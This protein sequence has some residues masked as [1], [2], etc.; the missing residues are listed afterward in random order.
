[1][2]SFSMSLSHHLNAHEAKLLADDAFASTLEYIYNEIYNAC[3]KGR[4]VV[5]LCAGMSP[6]IVHALQVQGYDVHFD[7]DE[8][9]QGDFWVISWSRATGE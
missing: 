7:K 9:G 2:P 8:R 4:T 6:E 5:T 1:M 3:I